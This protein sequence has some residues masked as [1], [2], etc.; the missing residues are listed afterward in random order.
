MTAWWGEVRRGAA[1]ERHGSSHHNTTA[2]S[3]RRLGGVTCGGV[4]PDRIIARMHGTYH[5][6]NRPLQLPSALS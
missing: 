2:G 4:V 5:T 1:N 6:Y 3:G